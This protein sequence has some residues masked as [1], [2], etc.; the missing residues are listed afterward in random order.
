M[1]VKLERLLAI[2]IMLMNRNMVQAKDLADLF[3]V[4]VRTI[5]R[6]IES[7]NQAGI[8]IVTQQGANGGISLLDGYRLDRSV[9]NHDELAS[10][11]TALQSLATSHRDTQHQLLV[12]KINS[13]IPRADI[14]NF[15]LKTKQ[16]IVDFSSWGE[17]YQ[18]EEKIKSIKQAIEG[19]YVLHFTYCSAQGSVT[20]RV[21]EP[22][23]LILKRSSWYV[24]G[25]CRVREQFRMFKLVRMKDIAGQEDSPFKR[26]DIALNDLPWQ[27]EWL[28]PE[29]LQEVVLRVQPAVRQRVE[30]W[31]GVENVVKHQDNQIIAT[32]AFPEDEWLIGF[33]LSFGP[34]IEVLEP[35]HIR[36]QIQT[37]AKSITQL[38]K[39]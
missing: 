32:G 4:S 34:D 25:F 30:E 27:K 18:L 15:K 20:Q 22:Y 29:N 13:V 14:E 2:V 24:Y 23:T 1:R 33:L 16:F 12:E 31:F 36:L 9:L 10:I 21:M 3:E 28:A 17:P 38:Y 7:I 39:T 35:E 19:Q 26:L 8:P 6:D 11:V 5:Y 37:R